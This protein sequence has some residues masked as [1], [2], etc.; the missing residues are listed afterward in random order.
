[1]PAFL[2]KLRDSGAALALAVAVVACLGSA[3]GGERGLGRALALESD[4]D[5]INQISFR[6]MQEI[7]EMREELAR[8]DTDDRTLEHLARRRLHLVQ[9]GDTLYRLG[10]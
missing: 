10:Q 7:D 5:G 6:E 4:L 2:Q 3:F 9:K 1:V 8:I